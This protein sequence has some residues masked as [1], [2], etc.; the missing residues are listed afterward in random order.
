MVELLLA[1]YALMSVLSVLLPY[2]DSAEFRLLAL[3]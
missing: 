2:K 1:Y 3:F